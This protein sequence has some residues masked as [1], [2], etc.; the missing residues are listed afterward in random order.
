MVKMQSFCGI[1]S[2]GCPIDVYV[3]NG[4]VV[5]VEGKVENGKS[6][7]LCAKGAASKQYLYNE[8]RILYPMKRV[9]ERGS[10]R[11]ERISWDEAY[12]LIVEN[13][14][15]VR[16]KYGARSVIFY[17]GYPK[18]YRPALL[19][20]SN[21]FG[22][23]NFCTES[24]TC[25]QASDLAWK[26]IYGN[27]I[28]F[29][30]LAHTKTLLVWSSNI[31]HSNTPMGKVYRSLKNRGVKIIAVDPRNTVTVKDADV[32][33]KLTPGTDG[34]LALAMAHVI[35]EENLY[36]K[37]FVDKYIYGFEEYREYVKEFTP[38]RGQEITGVD[39][40]LIRKAARL[41]ACGKP[42]G[43]QFSV[44]TIV[45]HINGFQ[46]YRA[47]FCL[48][49]LTGNYDRI[50][51]N[52]A[53][54]GPVSP[55]NEFGKVRRYNGEEAIG[56]KDFPVWF[57]LPCQEAQCTR[58]ADYILEEDP[59]PLKAMFAMGLNHRM[60]PQPEYMQQA[61]E[62]LDFYVNTE[63]FWS[64]SSKM[65][66]LVLPACTTFEREEV[67]M[68]RG[69]RFVLNQRAVEP[70]GEAKNDIEIIMEIAGR[71]QL[72]D[73]ILTS[74]YESYMNYILEPSGLT[75]NDLR[76]YPEGLQGKYLVP[77]RERT[78]ETEMFHTPSG[79]IE[80]CSLVLEKYKESRGYEGLPVYKDF[81]D[82][83]EIDR[84]QFPLILNT[85]SRKPQFFH[86]RV[87]RMTWLS[88][89]EVNPMVEIHP[90]DGKIYGLEDGDRVKV[91]SPAGKMEGVVSYSITGNPG[92]VYIY[93]GNK[94]GEANNLIDRNYVDPY[95]GFPGYKSYFCRIE[96]IEE[97][98]TRDGGES[99]WHIG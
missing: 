38:E 13:L 66:D 75:L 32:H 30:D 52:R 55:C 69:G 68:L 58:L 37:E 22:S 26:S 18:W 62:K 21:A 28:C 73:E 65:A 12:D 70:V 33:L 90:E 2:R 7:G 54:A 14:M 85:G 36:D 61:L 39:A 53:M 5:S 19:R 59:Y 17:A 4:R 24:S 49:A 84:E 48:I 93:H 6:Q 25:F 97:E 56:E 3:E 80:F 81:R 8:D 44:S 78:Y 57:D 29:P 34:A 45:H 83:K 82:Q 72:K 79:K 91:S 60:W 15:K 98:E 88:N 92:V 43:I 47:V 63:L 10:G 95:T 76:K 31:F 89:L 16:E 11:F 23:P 96:K 77:P 27:G 35:I 41:Y 9:G 99:I 1:C 42:S 50:G 86:A 67:K 74:G 94:N 46:N 87:Y 71:M 20:L 51:G 40:E 64:D